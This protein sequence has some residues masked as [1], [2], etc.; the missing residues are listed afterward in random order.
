MRMTSL[1]PAETEFIL[2]T[3]KELLGQETFEPVLEKEAIE[4]AIELLDAAYANAEEVTIE[5]R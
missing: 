1:T 4:E 3:L 2:D 5:N